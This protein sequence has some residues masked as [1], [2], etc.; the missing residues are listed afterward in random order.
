MVKWSTIP[1][2]IGK[3]NVDLKAETYKLLDFFA[4]FFYAKW[5]YCVLLN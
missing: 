4:V 1:K 3:N 2:N 5:I